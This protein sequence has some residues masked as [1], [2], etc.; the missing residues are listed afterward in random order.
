MPPLQEAIFSSMILPL[1]PTPTINPQRLRAMSETTQK[2]RKPL[3]QIQVQITS[4]NQPPPSQVQIPITSNN[5]SPLQV[6]ITTTMHKQHNKR[7]V[8]KRIMV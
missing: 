5:Q 6:P 4:N 8:V 3:S 2:V 1:P 7:R